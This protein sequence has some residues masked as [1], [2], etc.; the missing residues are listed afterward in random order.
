MPFTTLFTCE[1]SYHHLYLF[2]D[3]FKAILEKADWRSVTYDEK[4][5]PIMLQDTSMFYVCARAKPGTAQCC[6]A[7]CQECFNKATTTNGRR[8][9]GRSVVT[10]SPNTLKHK[11]CCHSLHDLEPESAPWWCD[12]GRKR[13]GLFSKN[14]MARNKGCVGCKR[15]FVWKA[16]KDW[17]V[18]K[19]DDDV[20]AMYQK[21]HDGT[22][23]ASFESNGN[24]QGC[25]LTM[26]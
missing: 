10:K 18:S 26:D 15:M 9:R 12:P 5:E 7:V 13:D 24:V 8:S 19:L 25:R 16:K 21:L 6:H 1:F 3:G 11:Q 4:S 14:W 2:Q 23:Q 20:R 17:K 22:L